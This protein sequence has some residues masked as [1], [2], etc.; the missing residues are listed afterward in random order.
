MCP[1]WKIWRIVSWDHEIPNPW[2]I[3]LSA[4]IYMVLHG[5]HQQKHP[6]N[7]SINIAAPWIR[8]GQFMWKVKIPMVPVTHQPALS[9]IGDSTVEPASQGMHLSLEAVCKGHPELAAQHSQ[10]NCEMII[11][12]SP[13][14][15]VHIKHLNFSMVPLWNVEFH[16]PWF[17]RGVF[18]MNGGR[19][20]NDGHPPVRPQWWLLIRL[21]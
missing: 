14:H 4:A 10:P 3:H 18:N 21:Y 16:P 17:L 11:I 19:D 20:Y 5:S 9:K 6:I 2:R 8:H 15:I 1:S 12:P 13:V 7:V